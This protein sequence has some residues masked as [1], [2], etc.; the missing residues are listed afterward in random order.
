LWHGY[1]DATP[2][3]VAHFIKVLKRLKTAPCLQTTLHLGA[4]MAKTM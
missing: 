3:E 1:G 4:L 2:L